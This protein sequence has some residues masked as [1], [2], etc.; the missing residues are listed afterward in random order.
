M[1]IIL[2]LAIAAKIRVI[3]WTK[4]ATRTSTFVLGIAVGGRSQEWMN[5]N[6]KNSKLGYFAKNRLKQTSALLP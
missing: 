3:D 1:T 4:A 5:K 2:Q 6:V